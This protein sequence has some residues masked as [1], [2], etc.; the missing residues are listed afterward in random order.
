MRPGTGSSPEGPAHRR[1]SG[2]HSSCPLQPKY[3]PGASAVVP[4]AAV[5]TSSTNPIA[6]SAPVAAGRAPAVSHD[7]PVV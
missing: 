5:R 4:V 6:G 3:S 1:R 2:T 7:E